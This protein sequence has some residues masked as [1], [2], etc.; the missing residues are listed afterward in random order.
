MYPLV[1]E[2]YCGSIGE[3]LCFYEIHEAYGC[4]KAQDSSGNYEWCET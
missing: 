4:V 1:R 2:Q 3:Y